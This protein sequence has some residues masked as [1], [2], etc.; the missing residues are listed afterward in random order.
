VTHS[1]PGKFNP[2]GNFGANLEAPDSSPIFLAVGDKISGTG[3]APYVLPTLTTAINYTTNVVSGKAPANR[4][5]EAWV[6]TPV[7]YNWYRVYTRSGPTGLYSADFTSQLDLISGEPYVAEAYSVLP[8]TGNAT[9]Y[10]RA[11]GP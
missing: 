5:M 3:V 4:Y 7:P 9:D 1:F 10:Y 8:T 11:I 2:F 6:W